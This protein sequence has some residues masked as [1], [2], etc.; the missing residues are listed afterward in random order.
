VRQTV[1]YTVPIDQK[2]SFEAWFAPKG[3]DEPTIVSE[4]AKKGIE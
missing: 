2:L 4:L 1:L 3:L